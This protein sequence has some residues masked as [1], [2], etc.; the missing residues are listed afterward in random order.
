MALLCDTVVM[1]VP[2]KSHDMDFLK[3]SPWE[4]RTCYIARE[5][6]RNMAHHSHDQSHPY[7][8]MLTTLINSQLLTKR[9]LF[10]QSHISKTA[11]NI[12]LLLWNVIDC[13]QYSTFLFQ[14]FPCLI[15]FSPVLNYSPSFYYGLQWSIHVA[16]TGCISNMLTTWSPL[17]ML[18]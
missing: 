14:C 7:C 11:L 13:Q 10:T 1:Y 15:F 5:S 4:Q 18:N 2:F 9:H 12:C 8:H 17:I 3:C 6:A 16:N